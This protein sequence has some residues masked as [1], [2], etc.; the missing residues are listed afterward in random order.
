MFESVCF[1]DEVDAC[2]QFP[3]FAQTDH[4][5]ETVPVCALCKF[6]IQADSFYWPNRNNNNF[7]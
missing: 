2:F 6:K 3:H 5:I 1:D 7:V 4:D